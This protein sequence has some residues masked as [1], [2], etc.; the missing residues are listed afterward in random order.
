MNN[1]LDKN[2][3]TDNFNPMAFDKT[4]ITKEQIVEAVQNAV[5]MYKLLNQTYIIK[6]ILEQICLKN[7]LKLSDKEKD[8][9]LNHI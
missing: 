8:D 7:D 3:T 9:I 2:S 1:K 6:D 5:K 4:T